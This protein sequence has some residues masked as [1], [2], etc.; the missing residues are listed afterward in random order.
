L[1]ISVAVAVS[2]GRFLTDPTFSLMGMLPKNQLF[3]RNV[4]KQNVRQSNP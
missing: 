3:L 4:Y 2:V 1:F